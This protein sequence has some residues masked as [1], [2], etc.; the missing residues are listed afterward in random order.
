MLPDMTLST[1]SDPA[2]FVGGRAFPVQK[3]IDYEL[4]P[5]AIRD[6][7]RGLMHQIWRA[8]MENQ[9]VYLSAPNVAEF[10][11]LDLPKVTEIS[12]TFDQNA[13]PIFAYVQDGIAKLYW[14]DASIADYVTTVFGADVLTPR[15][16]LD[17]K[18]LTQ[19]SVSDVLLFYQRDSKLMMRMQRERFSIEHALASNV[20]DGVVKCGMMR[21]LRVGVQLAQYQMAV[22][23]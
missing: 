10:V 8:R 4:G 22:N 23:I 20:T 1:M 13:N 21:N 19:R 3:H 16:T 7:A 11:L 6:P 18:R 15:I 5:I 2:T 14:F 12:F 17:D 9:Y